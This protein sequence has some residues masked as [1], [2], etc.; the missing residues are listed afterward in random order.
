MSANGTAPAEEAIVIHGPVTGDPRRIVDA[1]RN[2]EALERP[3]VSRPIPPGITTPAERRARQAA[4]MSQ[5]VRLNGIDV[6]RAICILAMTVNFALPVS[7]LLPAWMYHMQNPPPTG[8]YVLRAGLT[9]P[10]IV[11]P[12][13][14]FAMA[15]A[16]PL[17]NHLL[18]VGG[19]TRARI[20]W[21]AVK[22]AVMLYLFALIIG[23]SN[24]FYTQLYTKSGNL[25]AIA[26][27][28]TS[29]ALFVR[30]PPQISETAF[31]WIRR[32]G[33]L[34]AIAVLIILPTR[35]DAGFSLLRRD[36]IITSTAFVYLCCTLV[37]LA[38]RERMLVRMA[39]MVVV[40]TLKLAAPEV[41]LLG[42][43]MG[44]A[45]MQW[46]YEPWFFELLLI[47]IPGII[48]GEMINEYIM[49]AR[50][51]AAA[52]PSRPHRYL[53]LLGLA[54]PVV[55]LV[56]LYQRYVTATM[57]A[58]AALVACGVALLLG[59]RNTV[60]P[61]VRRLAAMS[62]ILIIVG[63]LL[64]PLEG[65]IKKDPQTLSYLLTCAGLWCAVGLSLSVLLDEQSVRRPWSQ[66]LIAVGQNPM[67]AYVVF[68]L[69]VSHLAYLAGIGD[70]LTSSA[71]ALVLRAT[72]VVLIVVGMA[73]LAARSRLIWKA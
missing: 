63:L 73:Q 51:P 39:I 6:L 34:G 45:G 56:G 59:R 71:G 36:N 41:P 20:A 62:A 37:W 50:E 17:R 18:L 38:T 31:S 12:G 70:S 60:D 35:W 43:V 66:P 55:L 53:A 54:V 2:D 72:I 69:F 29:F 1:Q 33:W 67:F 11:F 44:A 26:G 42:S 7:S 15:A 30:R 47:G 21:E 46:L 49:R 27:F 8:A 23:H 64:E 28:L 13:F 9:W 22:R 68:M 58:T 19:E 40:A 57:V 48:A 5:R 65:G 61:T 10:D 3:L 16:I 25:L 4:A 32:A 52:V 24:P 14:L